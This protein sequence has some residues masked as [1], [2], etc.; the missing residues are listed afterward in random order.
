MMRYKTDEKPSTI[1][2]RIA[3][4]YT[5]S[6]LRK[7]AKYFAE[8]PW[9]SVPGSNPA[10]DPEIGL[11]IHEQ[12][13]KECHEQGGRH[14]DA[15]MPRV[16]GQWPEYL[17]MQLRAYRDPGEGMFQPT[18]MLDAVKDLSDEELLGL[19]AYYASQE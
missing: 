10:A 3:R 6:Q 19:A 7:I 18:K 5:P 1:M 14:Q 2:G 8:Q 9:E 12:S 11:R 15:D 13:C 4:G 16:A 17:Y